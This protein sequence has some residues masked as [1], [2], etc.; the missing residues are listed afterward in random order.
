MS[1]TSCYCRMCSCWHQQRQQV[2]CFNPVTRQRRRTQAAAAAAGQ[3]Q[4][5]AYPYNSGDSRQQKATLEHIFKPDV[6]GSSSSSSASTIQAPWTVGWQVSRATQHLLCVHFEQ[7]VVVACILKHVY[8]YILNTFSYM[9]AAATGGAM[10]CPE[11]PHPAHAV[12]FMRHAPCTG[13]RPVHM[14]MPC[15]RACR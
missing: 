14:C 10:Y 1:S 9:W 11:W 13:M 7:L 4:Q 2:Q 6:D 15:L 8:M 12:Q 5:P 3:Q